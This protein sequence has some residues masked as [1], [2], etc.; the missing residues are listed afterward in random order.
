MINKNASEAPSPISPHNSFHTS[1]L[2]GIYSSYQ[3]RIG[4]TINE[5]YMISSQLRSDQSNTDS[6]TAQQLNEHSRLLTNILS[7]Q[8]NLHDLLQTGR[9]PDEPVRTPPLDVPI[10]NS[11]RSSS[12]V[13]YIRASYHKRSPC[14]PNCNCD[15]HTM[16]TLQ[17][18]AIVNHVIGGLFVGYSGYPITGNSH[19]CTKASC[20]SRTTF[21]AYVQY[22]FPSWFLARAIIVGLTT[23]SLNKISVS[24]KVQRVVPYGSEIFRLARLDD[25]DGLKELFR[26]GLAS[27]NDISL[28]GVSALVVS[29]SRL[30]VSRYVML[31]LNE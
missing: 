16:H 23:Q 26:K 20:L 4:L 31:M 12:Q 11:D 2:T 13:V 30:C 22:I 3:S 5:I 15:C 7:S 8:S 27:P 28:D 14:P 21:R 29:F 6:R 18:P 19:K 1:P 10:H 17:S 9:E 24:L 25:A